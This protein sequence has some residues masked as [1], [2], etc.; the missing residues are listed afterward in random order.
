M[1]CV[2][3]Y[4]SIHAMSISTSK[5]LIFSSSS[6]PVF[7]LTLEYEILRLA[8]RLPVHSFCML[9]GGPHRFRTCLFL[10]TDPQ[11]QRNIT[12]ISIAMDGFSTTD[13]PQAYF[14]FP[15]KEASC[16][17]RAS[18]HKGGLRAAAHDSGQDLYARRVQQAAHDS[19]Q[20]LHARRIIQA[21]S[22]DSGSEDRSVKIART[23]AARQKLSGVSTSGSAFGVPS[24]EPVSA[25]QDLSDTP[26]SGSTTPAKSRLQGIQNRLSSEAL[27]PAAL[28]T[29][30][31]VD[32]SAPSLTLRASVRAYEKMGSFR[33]KLYR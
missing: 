30:K 32:P 10:Q 27:A 14:H 12:T 16:F 33:G 21:W 22:D 24:M 11:Y 2:S 1:L 8:S 23:T 19:P 3:L 13:L 18:D 29:T 15:I 31:A 4:L 17:R 20:A 26:F 5:S 25:F 6:N 9:V 7:Y 28:S